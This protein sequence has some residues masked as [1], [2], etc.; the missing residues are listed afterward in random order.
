LTLVIA[1]PGAGVAG[2]ASANSL[3][4]AAEKAV[5]A[6]EEGRKVLIVGEGAWKAAR[7][8]W[9]KLD[10]SGGNNLLVWGLDT[11]EAQLAGTKLEA[12]VAAR[13]S[14]IEWLRL[15]QAGLR[16]SAGKRLARRDL[17]RSGPAAVFQAVDTPLVTE[18]GACSRLTS[19]RLCVEACP[20][21]ALD[22]KPPQ[23]DPYRCTSCGLCTSVCPVGILEHAAAGDDPAWRYL[24]LLGA[25]GPGYLVLVCRSDA[26]KMI[27]ALR[28][29]SSTAR[30]VLLPVTCP[31]QAG[32]RLLLAALG[33]G[34]VPVYACSSSTVKSC[35]VEAFEK[36]LETVV[37]DYARLTGVKPVFA[38]SPS[39]LRKALET[40]PGLEPAGP[41]AKHVWR[42]AVE[43]LRARPPRAR[44]ETRTPLLGIVVVDP[45]KCTLCGACA[46]ACPT[47]ALEL[48]ETE[49]GSK[50]VFRPDRCAP[51]RLC[52]EACPEDAITVS[53]ATDPG[54]LAEDSVVLHMEEVARCRVCGKPIG[55]LRMLKTVEARL[56]SAGAPEAA[57][58]RLYLC[59][60]CKQKAALGLV[61][62]GQ[63]QGQ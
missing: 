58:E 59:T 61:N 51:C 46:N 56:R 19:C 21:N 55:P 33:Y 17:L 2:A 23:P 45:G 28:G 22:G 35:G 10:R 60:E 16:A 1:L 30:A 15:D 32:L 39:E 48:V 53:Y 9:S 27:D 4:D 26:A 20:Y 13:T 49:E 42:A 25:Q 62:L 29:D 18:P 24:K 57:I 5:Q 8:A 34:L 54:L 3:A 41:G 6:A 37:G 43:T 7:E 44:V 38:P 47:S 63:Q 12:A 14:L 50:L 31:G 11:L 52:V 36:Y 40:T